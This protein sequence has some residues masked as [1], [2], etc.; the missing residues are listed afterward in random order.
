MSPCTENLAAGALR[1]ACKP[2]EDFGLV[3]PVRRDQTMTCPKSFVT[4]IRS[5][6]TTLSLVFLITIGTAV[7]GT[8]N[9]DEALLDA[10]RDGD[11]GKVQNLVEEGADINAQNSNG[12][13]PL[14]FAIG[15]AHS[16]LVKLLLKLGADPN[17]PTKQGMTPLMEAALRNDATIATLLLD[18]N[19]ALDITNRAGKTAL[20]IAAENG[21]KDMVKLLQQYA[22]AGR[23]RE[24]LDAARDG[25][26]QKVRNLL[27]NGA[28]V[29]TQDGNGWTPLMFAV[30]S[31]HTE[32]V[33][34]LLQAGADV[35][36][37]NAA[38]DTVLEFPA[39][40]GHKDV[41]DL[42][43]RHGAQR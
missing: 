33:K 1:D 25:A 42:L 41:R 26:L 30:S 15:S 32:L 27:A 38:G 11:L 21:H 36:I 23:D 43:E 39:L 37:R 20:D 8:L 29:N 13:T 14:M 17:G 2:V 40:N 35:N 28:D 3:M 7:A 34:M 10:A 22:K 31:A 12:L 4:G 19:A 9:L 6:V 16:D 5:A 24:L 18:A